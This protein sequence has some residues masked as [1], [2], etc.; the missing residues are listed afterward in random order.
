MST[1][2]QRVLRDIA[3]LQQVFSHL[4]Q[5]YWLF[6]SP[7]SKLW[8]EWY[9]QL[10]PLPEPA[11]SLPVRVI[12]QRNQDCIQTTS[13]EA[14]IQSAG[15]VRETC[16]YGLQ[17]QIHNRRL[18]SQARREADLET[19]IAAQDLGFSV[20]D[21]FMKV[22]QGPVVDVL[23]LLNDTQEHWLP[24]QLSTSA[25]ANARIDVLRWLQRVGIALMSRQLC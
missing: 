10:Q 12:L 20:T 6:A 3:V 21:D 2:S 7:V 24:A 11:S 9:E 22:Q 14:A 18:Q 1:A 5:G 4:G 16:E 17:A 25:A 8:K 23:E 13:F 15:C 19:L